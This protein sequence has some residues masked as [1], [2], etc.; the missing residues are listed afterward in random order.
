MIC[1]IRNIFIVFA[2]FSMMI[3]AQSAQ[4]H[5]ETPV[6]KDFICV[7]PTESPEFPGGMPAIQKFIKA[8]VQYPKAIL[9][10][11]IY[12]TVYIQFTV[13]TTGS[14]NDIKVLKGI[15]DCL[16][17]DEEA[18]RLFSIMPKWK[19]GKINGI[20]TPTHF[21]FPLKFKAS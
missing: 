4:T 13:D 10:K 5:T 15:K 14:V 20:P 11:G 12:G 6:A 17:C 1:C 7:N 2:F 21:N 19:P 3:R 16:E 9:E 18:K 8:N